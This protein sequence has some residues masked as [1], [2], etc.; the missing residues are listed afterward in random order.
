MLKNLLQNWILIG[1][2]TNHVMNP[3][4]MDLFLA[5]ISAGRHHQR[6]QGGLRQRPAGHTWCLVVESMG[7]TV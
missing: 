6:D 1:N 5:Y 7:Q 2:F 4:S 3:L